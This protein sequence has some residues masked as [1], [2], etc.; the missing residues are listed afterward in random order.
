MRGRSRRSAAAAVVLVGGFG[1]GSHDDRAS[2]SPASPQVTD[3]P[4]HSVTDR[5][6]LWSAAVAS[7][8]THPVTGRRPRRTS[9]RTAT[10]TP[11]SRCPPAATPRAPGRHSSREPL[12]SPHNMYLL[13]LS[14]QGLLGLLASRRRLGWP[15]LGLR[16]L[17]PPRRAAVG[18]CRRC[19]GF[20]D[21]GLAAVGLLVWTLVDFLYGD[22]GGPRPY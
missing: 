20:L 19:A 10:A 14:E 17:R 12:L 2:G 11:P 8:A 1:V 5:Y 21:C 3:A 22:I 13:V 6:T 4:D 18:R 9:P 15:L 7:G 16:R